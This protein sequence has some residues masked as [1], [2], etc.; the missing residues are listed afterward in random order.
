KNAT[1][2][3]EGL[4]TLGGESRCATYETVE[5]QAPAEVAKGQR[6]KIVLLTPAYFANGWWPANF[7][8][9]RWVGPA[10]QWVS[11]ALG[12][13]L[14]ISGWDIVRREPKA[15]YHYVPAGSVFYFENASIPT[16]PFTET[17]D[18][19]LPAAQMGFGRI[20]V[21]TWNYLNS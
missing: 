18:A 13:P 15:L 5:Y 12:K 19:A 6:L 11:V 1:L 4:L 16:V 20:A 10:A 2:A 14:P 7:D 3:K 8:W 9:S 17:P 21:G